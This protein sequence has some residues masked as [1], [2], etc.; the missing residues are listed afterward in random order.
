M[1]T[2]ATC[3]QPQDPLQRL[4]HRDLGRAVE[5]GIAEAHRLR[6]QAF[7]DAIHQAGLG[8]AQIFGLAGRRLTLRVDRPGLTRG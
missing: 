2:A 7:R 4:A 8:L 3:V 1:R 6:A 5:Q